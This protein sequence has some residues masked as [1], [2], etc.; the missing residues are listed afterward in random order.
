[1]D[2]YLGKTLRLNDVIELIWDPVDSFL[3]LSLSLDV[4]PRL[5]RWRTIRCWPLNQ[6][7]VVLATYSGKPNTSAIPLCGRPTMHWEWRDGESSMY[8]SYKTTRSG[9][10]G[11]STMLS[12]GANPFSFWRIRVKVDIRRSRTCICRVVR[13]PQLGQTDSNR[14]CFSEMKTRSSD[15]YRS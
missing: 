1:M 7:F 13:K 11:W 2:L 12:G 6:D 14:H 8:T 5:C 3:A 9:T 10:G 4:V 15:L